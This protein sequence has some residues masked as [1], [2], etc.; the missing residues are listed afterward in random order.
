MAS[1]WT[2]CISSLFPGSWTLHLVLLLALVKGYYQ[3]WDA[4]SGLDLYLWS[5]HFAMRRV[6]LDKPLVQEEWKTHG[7]Y[8][9][10]GSKLGQ[11]RFRL[12]EHLISCWC[13]REKIHFYC[14]L[15]LRFYW[16]RVVTQQCLVHFLEFHFFTIIGIKY[17]YTK[18]KKIFYSIKT[19]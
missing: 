18:C 4:L 19:L 7:A 1:R 12:V 14:C 11:T 15:P 17:Q 6:I 2:G 3:A 5:L 10:P 8:P 16:W 9:Q 13:V